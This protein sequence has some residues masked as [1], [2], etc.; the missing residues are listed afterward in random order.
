MSER[1]GGRDAPASAGSSN[2]K[3]RIARM[4]AR[5]PSLSVDDIYSKLKETD[6]HPLS[7]FAISGI[8]NDV[9]LYRKIFIDE[10]YMDDDQREKRR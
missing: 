5:R 3:A 6:D 7:K 9:R 4:L 2:I 1:S 10:G 8:R